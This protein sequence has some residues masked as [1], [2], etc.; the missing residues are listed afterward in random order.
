MIRHLL[1]NPISWLALF[2]S[3]GG[4]SYA[5]NTIVAPAPPAGP[6]TDDGSP[7]IYGSFFVTVIS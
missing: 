2:V 1:K 6:T 3:L 4:T 5:A 7:T